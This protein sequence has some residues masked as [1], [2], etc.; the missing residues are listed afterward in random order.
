M[1]DDHAAVTGQDPGPGGHKLDGHN[2]HTLERLFAHPTSHN[3]QWHDVRSL[4][5]QVGTVNEHPDGKFVVRIGDQTE[6][7]EPK[8]SHDMDIEHVMILRRALSAAG[9]T[10]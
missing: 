3:I 6:T 2:R 5:D 8:R 9:I 1:T 10:P 4:L 7:F